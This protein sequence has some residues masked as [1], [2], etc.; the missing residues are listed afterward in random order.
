MSEYHPPKFDQEESLEELCETL[1]EQLLRDEI[2]FD[3]A[4]EQLAIAGATFQGL[5]EGIFKPSA[6]LYS[7]LLEKF[8]DHPHITL[9]PEV[10]VASSV[11]SGQ[12]VRQPVLQL[13]SSEQGTTWCVLKL[14]VD[15]G[16]RYEDVTVTIRTTSS[17]ELALVGAQI[18]TPTN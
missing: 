8:E 12:V 15:N 4:V 1:N 3:E 13:K 16:E 5:P 9:N 6:E 14:D 18:S 17:G 7:E 10:L 2:S 11:H